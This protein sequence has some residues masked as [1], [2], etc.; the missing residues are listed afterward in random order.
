LVPEVLAFYSILQIMVVTVDSA[1][2]LWLKAAAVVAVPLQ[3]VP[4]REAAKMG[5]QAVVQRV[6]T[7]PLAQL[8]DMEQRHRAITVVPRVQVTH[9]LAVAVVVPVESAQPLHRI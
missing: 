1:H 5:V 2:S 9:G 4:L 3:R 8:S 7:V 6:T